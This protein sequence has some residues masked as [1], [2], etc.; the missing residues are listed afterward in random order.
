MVAMNAG[1][2]SVT[3]PEQREPDP[4]AALSEAVHAAMASH[5]H[6]HLTHV[7]RLLTE[8]GRKVSHGSW[9]HPNE[10][11][12]RW[13]VAVAVLVA[14]GLQVIS[15]SELAL[16]PIWL[17]PGLEAALLI[18]LIVANP[19]RIVHGRPWV[20][21]SSITLV[22]LAT[23]ANA[24]SAG[25]LID[26]LLNHSLGATAVQLLVDGGGIWLTNVIIFALWYWEFDRGGPAERAKGGR[27]PD[28][29]F[30]QMQ[31]P[32]IA[33]ANWSP[34]FVDYL[35]LSFTN[36]MAFSPTDTLP[37]NRWAKLL[38]LFQSLVS[39]VTVALVVARAVNILQ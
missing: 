29:Q 8:S 33:Q 28:F 14:I 17:L 38:M 2:E 6:Q 26:G 12:A 5:L 25:K 37:L 9:F 13:P 4:E 11:E 39:L 27:L 36:A 32:E 31:T 18:L 30:P 7:E 15:P 22:A 23:A 34:A 16:H 19:G 24:W 3:L 21:V 1:D 35:Y 10:G 20:R